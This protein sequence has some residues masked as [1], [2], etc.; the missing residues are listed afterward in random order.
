MFFGSCMNGLSDG[1]TAQESPEFDTG[2]EWMKSDEIRAPQNKSSDLLPTGRELVES[3]PLKSFKEAR[4]YFLF[5]N[6]SR[7]FVPLE[8]THIASIAELFE[9]AGRADVVNRAQLL[10]SRV[11]R[12]IWYSA[13]L[14]CHS[15]RSQS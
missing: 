10:S 6:A 7:T 11:G 4:N 9:H 12:N 14:L 3:S 8:A 2:D 1:A 13:R 5:S 15:E